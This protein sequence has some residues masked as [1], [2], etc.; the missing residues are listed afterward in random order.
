MS[1]APP[2]VSE[3]ARPQEA[4]RPDP[5][6]SPRSFARPLRAPAPSAVNVLGRDADEGVAWAEL[7]FSQM[8][9]DVGGQIAVPPWRV[10]ICRILSGSW[11][12]GSGSRLWIREPW[13]NQNR[14]SCKSKK[15]KSPSVISAA[16]RCP[17][18]ILTRNWLFC[19]RARRLAVVALAACSVP[20]LLRT[21]QWGLRIGRLMLRGKPRRRHQVAR[22]SRW[23]VAT[24]V[25]W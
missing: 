15:S 25:A 9:P 5:G 18:E 10:P 22:R 20:C 1:V 13:R 12:R 3:V 4:G 16:R 23:V 7:A 24:Q 21:P 11:F 14:W 6:L 19:I 8:R 2:R 17:L